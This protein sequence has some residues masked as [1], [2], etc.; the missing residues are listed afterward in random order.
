MCLINTHTSKAYAVSHIS[1]TAMEACAQF[2]ATPH[3]SACIQHMGGSVS[4][5]SGQDTWGKIKIL[6][7]F[8]ESN[9]SSLV[10][11]TIVKLLY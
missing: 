4:P 1:T 7:L 2:N 3:L 9:H 6:G 5:R 8:Q 10:G 11:Q